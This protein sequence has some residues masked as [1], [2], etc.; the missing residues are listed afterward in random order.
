MSDESDRCAWCDR[1]M[2]SPLTCSNCGQSHC[3]QRCLSEHRATRC[4]RRAPRMWLVLLI[5]GSI[6]LAYFLVA[7]F[8]PDL[9]TLRFLR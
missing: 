8:A 3:S 4:P 2:R 1:R 5:T 7:I 6:L 9:L